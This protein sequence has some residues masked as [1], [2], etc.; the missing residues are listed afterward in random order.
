MTQR[1]KAHIGVLITNL[2]YGINFSVMQHITDKLM[3]PVAL[4]ML[5]I[6]GAMILFWLL[7]FIKPSNNK[8]E[9]KDLP[10]LIACAFTGILINQ[11]L[12]VKGNALTTN[13]RAALLMLITPIAVVFIATILLREKIQFQKMLGLFMGV[14]G[15][16]LLISLKETTQA[17]RNHLLGDLLII[18]NALSYAFY[19]VLIKPL[20][21]HYSA[22]ALIR[23]LFT[24][25][26]FVLLPFSIQPVSEIDW[27]AF[28]PEDYVMVSFVVIGVTFLAYLLNVYSIKILG[29]TV[30]GAYIYSQPVFAAIISIVVLNDQTNLVIKA[31]AALFIFLGVYLVSLRKTIKLL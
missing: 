9:K 22:I 17:G 6:G 20:M 19:L 21:N 5:R 12:F 8:I 30:T 13:T 15:A 26:F 14:I 4:N 25:A 24:I 3:K 27:Q 1:T 2:F 11:I 23:W 18:I 29:S 10:R 28:R 7:Y 16:V 31:I